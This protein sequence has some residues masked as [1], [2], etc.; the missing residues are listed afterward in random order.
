MIENPPMLI[1][2]G[3]VI[4]AGFDAELDELRHRQQRR[5][6]PA[7]QARERE[8]TGLPSLKVG[9]NKIHGF[10]IEISRAQAVNAPAN[11]IRRQ[12]CAERYITPELQEFEGKALSALN[13]ALAREKDLYAD[14]LARLVAVLAPL[15]AMA[16][17]L[18]ECSPRWRDARRNSA[19]AG[20][21]GLWSPASTS[22]PDVTRWW[23]RCW[24]SP[25]I[26]NDLDLNRSGA[27]W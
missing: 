18:A 17:A 5:P 21:T 22:A 6:L 23:S 20:R 26:A 8:R 2:D 27:C 12:T 10:Y 7:G 9:Y 3:G 13:L 1:R 16:E 24:S 14:L 4:A 11:Y 25:F 15:R 19:G